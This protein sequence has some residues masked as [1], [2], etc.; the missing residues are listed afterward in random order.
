MRMSF[1]PRGGISV[2][3]SAARP[4]LPCSRANSPRVAEC[5]R[6]RSARLAWAATSAASPSARSERSASHP[7]AAVMSQSA[8]RFMTE[9]TPQVLSGSLLRLLARR[10]AGTGRA[11][12]RRLGIRR[13]CWLGLDVGGPVALTHAALDVGRRLAR[14]HGIAVPALTP[15]GAG[16]LLAAPDIALVRGGRTAVIRGLLEA[17]FAP[18]VALA[19]VSPVPPAA[20]AADG[21]PGVGRRF[22]DAVLH[23]PA[24]L[25]HGL[26]LYPAGRDHRSHGGAERDA[27]PCDQHRLLAAEIQQRAVWPHG[28]A[29]RMAVVGGLA[30]DSAETVRRPFIQI[31]GP[32]AQALRALAQSLAGVFRCLAGTAHGLV[33]GGADPIA[34]ILRPP[35]PALLGPGDRLA[36]LMRPALRGVLG[37][38][39]GRWAMPAATEIVGNAGGP[40]PLARHVLAP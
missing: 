12:F 23:P 8:I 34:D 6:L 27:Q 3:R 24:G 14:A 11:C 38:L 26:A 15:L 28:V 10:R 35:A 1:Q 40:A 7:V 5:S 39:H 37:A 31:A 17:V 36:C 33:V 25:A 20:L 19:L 32:L 13:P 18:L 16:W 9:A 29:R 21:T 22:L 30:R 4:R 2:G